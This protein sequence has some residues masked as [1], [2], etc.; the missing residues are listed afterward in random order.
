MVRCDYDAWGRHATT[1]NSGFYL[2]QLNP[3]RYRG[4]YYDTETALYYLKAR[5]YDPTVGRFINADEV[6]YLDP[7][8]VGGLN[9]YAYCGN[10][11]VMRVDPNGNA[12]YDVL[13]WIGIGLVVAALTVVTL[14]AFGIVAGGVIGGI[15]MGAA[16]GTLIG[17]ATGVVLGAAGGMIYDAVK[18]N[19]FGTSIWTG[20][21]I[22]FGI[23]AIAGAVIGGAIGGAVASSV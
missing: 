14:G 7:E 21:K 20:V 16:I 8:T 3:F 13:A 17:A 6:N 11:P 5:Y 4:Y 15:I 19:A 9:L 18:G 2:G 22:G 10:N 23:G 12:W 1:D